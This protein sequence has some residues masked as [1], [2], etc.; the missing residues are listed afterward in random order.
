MPIHTLE[1]TKVFFLDQSSNCEAAWGKKPISIARVQPIF[2]RVNTGKI[3]TCEGKKEWCVDSLSSCNTHHQPQPTLTP[4]LVLPVRPAF[5]FPSCGGSS[6][7]GGVCGVVGGLRRAAPVWWWVC[8][9]SENG[10]N[11]Q[12]A[13]LN[14]AWLRVGH[15]W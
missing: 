14:S 5:R 13:R 2:L 8:S 15:H 12:K 10:K 4:S 1:D 11:N 3:A 7:G 6:E 9:S